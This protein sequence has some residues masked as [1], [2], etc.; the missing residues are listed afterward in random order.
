MYL[1]HNA[2]GRVRP[3]VAE[4]VAAW[5]SASGGNPSSLHAAGRRARTAIDESREEVARLVGASPRQVVFTSGGTEANNLA[6]LGV[7]R[8]GGHIVS[9]A[10]EHAS[11]LGAL[12]AAKI[13]GCEVALV[14]PHHTGRIAPEQVADAVRENTVLVSVG[15]A[16]GEIGAIQEIPE[17]VHAVRSTRPGPGLRVHSDAVQAAGLLPLDVTAAGVDLLS[18]SGH[19]I[20]APPGIGALIVAREGNLE[21]I[22]HGGPQERERRAGTENVLGIVGFGV[23]ARLA[24]EERAAYASRA[25]VLKETLWEGLVRSPAPVCRFD[26]PHGLPNTLS[27]GF[28]GVRGDAVVLALD[29]CGVAASTGSACAAG[30]REPSHVLRAIGCD[31]DTARSGVRFS[32]GPEICREDVERAARVIADVVRRARSGRLALRPD[33]QHAAV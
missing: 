33:G 23:A 2:G 6:V 26:S 19:K 7:A 24:R 1:D 17:L 31:E 22:L 3:A 11:V 30:A 9:T 25:A 12:Q 32:L 4:A 27:V 16:N 8:P 29:L 13:R 18:L 15:W 20:G 14:H 21:P 10:I 5:L 28:S